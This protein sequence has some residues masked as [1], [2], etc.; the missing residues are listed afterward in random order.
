MRWLILLALAAATLSPGFAQSPARRP[1]TPQAPAI[2]APR[3]TMAGTVL[4]VEIARAPAGARVA[5]ARIDQPAATAI[6]VAP[7]PDKG[8]AKLPVPGAPGDYEL[9]LTLDRAG[10]PAVLQRRKL[11]VH[12]AT[13]RVGGPSRT[14]RGQNFACYGNGP[15]G[16]HDRVTL[17]P[18]D[19]PP[20]AIG[21]SFFPAENIESTLEAPDKPGS[22]ELRYVMN[23][24]LAENVVLVRLPVEVE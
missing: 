24:P 2:S 11:V 23:A 14:A 7:L 5:I 4:S 6:V 15:N 20:D 19:A 8:P 3:E 22:Y 12:R 17:V 13:A 10:A 9:R 21:A 1:A 16:E 18:R